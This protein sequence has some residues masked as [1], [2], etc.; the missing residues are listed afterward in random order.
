[1]KRDMDLVRK[2]LLYIESKED[3]CPITEAPFEGYSKLVLLEHYHIIY[4]AGLIRGELY[5]STSTADRVVKVMPFGLTWAGHDF[6]DIIKNESIWNKATDIVS[7]KLSGLPFDVLKA[8][9]IGL[10]RDAVKDT[11]KS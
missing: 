11:F 4:E 6:V 5:R 7:T 3:E 1:V 10:C 9:L 8:V 2:I